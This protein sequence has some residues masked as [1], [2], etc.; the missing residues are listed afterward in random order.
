[1]T[2]PSE[3]NRSGPYTGNG[4]TT[5]F[6]YDFRILSNQHL[7]VIKAD[8]NGDETT[9]ALTTNYTVSGVGDA[10]G[11]S[12]TVLVAPSSAEKITIL[13]NM[14]FTQETDL[15]NQG[16][17][18]AET[19]ED[20]LDAAAMRDQQL[21]EKLDR[22]I[23]VPASEDIGG[24][25]LATQLVININRLA[26]SADEIDTVAGI[27]D[28]VVTL[29]GIAADVSAVATVADV[30]DNSSAALL[31]V[32][33]VFTGNGAQTQWT[34]TRE[35][36]ASE[37]VF[38]WVGG[39]IQTTDDYLVTGDK[40]TIAPAVANGVK[41]RVVICA[42][43]SANTLIDLVDD[44]Q[45]AAAAAEAAAALAVGTTASW[46]VVLPETRTWLD[47]VR[48]NGMAEPR[49]PLTF[50]IDD[51][52]AELIDGGVWAS[53]DWITPYFLHDRP[54]SLL[55][56]KNPAT[57]IVQTAD[58]GLSFL[59][60]IGFIGDGVNR[61]VCDKAPNGF[62]N[63]QQNA[64]TIGIL[65]SQGG[66]DTSSNE[67]ATTAGAGTPGFGLNSWAGSNIQSARVNNT[68]AVNSPVTSPD[69][70]VVAVRESATRLVSYR[71]GV[72]VGASNASASIV[73]SSSA[74]TLLGSG[75][76]RSIDRLHL[77]FMGGALNAAQ[78]AVMQS[79]AST[80]RSTIG[81][82]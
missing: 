14:P 41:I 10:E 42:F 23:L 3:T 74:I 30:I 77:A 8:A 4:V 49:R 22:A 37:N 20:A 51:F 64:A 33:N 48:S 61:I 60:G 13:R 79:A 11:G 18:Y 16:A 25:N 66:N 2:V 71:D 31:M 82:F 52:I 57:V 73:P 70:F 81:N 58:A 59:P 45:T 28:D 80:L 46:G 6:D 50:A 76:G 65:L 63:Y 56:L 7:Q 29:A 68:A 75:T 78:V 53:L 40:L 19:V 44:A 62:A 36:A 21:A 15:E 27:R 47:R 67:I 54:A 35:P 1:M 12:I 69:G 9:L 32:E 34:L 43:M 39:A 24:T 38:V 17:Y 26:D 72:Q 55:S 5:V